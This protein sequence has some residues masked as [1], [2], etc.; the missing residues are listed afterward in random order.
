MEREANSVQY[1]KATCKASA[2]ACNG[3]TLLS[4]VCDDRDDCSG[5]NVCCGFRRNPG[6]PGLRYVAT[7]CVAAAMCTLAQG[8][9][10]ICDPNKRPDEC[11]NGSDCRASTALPGFHVCQ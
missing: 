6:P 5:G 10:R 7:Q 9:V 8:G 3:Q 11:P 4:V 1:E 2:D